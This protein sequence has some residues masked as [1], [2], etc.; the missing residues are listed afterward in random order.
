MKDNAYRQDIV[1]RIMLL[2]VS[3]VNYNANSNYRKY[4]HNYAA[5]FFY[6]VEYLN[7]TTL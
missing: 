5:E 3:G 4:S 1:T 6:V 2:Y 7:S